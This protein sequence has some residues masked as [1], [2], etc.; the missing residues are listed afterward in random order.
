MRQGTTLHIGLKR[1]KDLKQPVCGTY[2]QPIP[3]PP[4]RRI[5]CRFSHPKID[6]QRKHPPKKS[7]SRKLR[8]REIITFKKTPE[9]RAH[10]L[11]IVPFARTRSDDVLGLYHRSKSRFAQSA[12]DTDNKNG[13]IGLVRY[14]SR[15]LNGN[16]IALAQRLGGLTPGTVPSTGCRAQRLPSATRRRV[17]CSCF[18]CSV[19]GL[20][21]ACPFVQRTRLQAAPH[22]GFRGQPVSHVVTAGSLALQVEFISSNGDQLA[23]VAL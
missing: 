11:A 6:L 7:G 17:L 14:S 1:V 23:H 21:D 2:N 19:H 10:S 15:H 20:H 4:T 16:S 8:E 5:A 18:L 3:A 13:H 9:W 22:F 12:L